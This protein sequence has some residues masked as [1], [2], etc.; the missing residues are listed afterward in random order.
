MKQADEE[1]AMKVTLESGEEAMVEEFGQTS[2]GDILI[3]PEG[4]GWIK[5]SKVWEVLQM[6]EEQ[7]AKAS[8]V[9]VTKHTF[10]AKKIKD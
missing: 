6:M 9:E 3:K 5:G 7:Q 2:D 4:Y 8:G 1:F 10:T